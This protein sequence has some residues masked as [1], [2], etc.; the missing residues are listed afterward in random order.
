MAPTKR[1]PKTSG[2]AARSGWCFV[3]RTP[4]ASS[5]KTTNTPFA[6]EVIEQIA[7]V[8]AIEKEIRGLPA[9]RRRAVRQSKTKPLVEALKGRLDAMKY[10]LSTQSTILKAIDYTLNQW[11]GLIQGNRVKRC[12]TK[13]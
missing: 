11:G 10:G 9:E 4:G 8:Y 7:A 6:R 1:F 13:G 12:V 3:S 2:R 5:F